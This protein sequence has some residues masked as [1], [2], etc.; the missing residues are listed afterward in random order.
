MTAASP[1]QERIRNQL[2][3][4]KAAAETIR[5]RKGFMTKEELPTLKIGE[6]LVSVIGD[7]NVPTEVEK[8][9]VIMPTAQVGSIS[10]EERQLVLEST[11][12]RKKYHAGMAEHI[13]GRAFNR[14]MMEARGIDPGLEGEAIVPE[15]NL[16]LKHV[17]TID[18]SREPAP[19][20]A[21]RLAGIAA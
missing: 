12:L 1:L 13:A 5:P 21:R 4:I 20:A 14:R 8:V 16:Y 9:L 2:R 18:I 19:G 6:A 17:P 3:K 7:D 15:P 11:P 10:I